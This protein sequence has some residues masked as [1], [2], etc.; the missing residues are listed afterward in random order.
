LLLL[1]LET[2]CRKN[3]RMTSWWIFTLR[4]QLFVSVGQSKPLCVLLSTQ[5]DVNCIVVYNAMVRGECRL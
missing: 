3:E 4:C 2:V 5:R 1:P